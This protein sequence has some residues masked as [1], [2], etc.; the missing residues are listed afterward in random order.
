MTSREK[1]A[2]LRRLMK[3]EGVHAYV[4]PSND[5]HLSEYVPEFWK[6]REWVSGFTGSAGEVV[7]F[8]N[9]AGLWTDS[10]Y[11]LQAERQL[12]AQVV[13][14]FKVG[15]PDTPSVDEYLAK[16]LKRG[17][18][19]GI[20][21]QVLS[22]ERATA[23][24][25]TLDEKGIRLRYTPNFVD[26]LWQDRPPMPG[27]RIQRHADNLAG[28]TGEAKLN[29]MRAEMK[30]VGADAHIVTALDAIA[31]LFNV[32]GSDVAFVPVVVAYAVIDRRGAELFIDLKK[33]SPKL[34][35]WL[36]GFVRLRP[37]EAAGDA[38][39]A[40]GK[41]KAR[42]W[43]DPAGTNRWV[44]ERLKGAKIYRAP[45]PIIKAKAIKNEVQIRGLRTAQR[46]DGVAMV[47]F[48]HWLETAVKERRLRELDVAKK[49]DASREGEARYRGPSFDTIVGF[50]RNAAVVHYSPVT[51]ENIRLGKRGILLIDS[52]AQYL[53]GT[54]DITRTVTIGAPTPREK[55]LFTRVL[56]GN[57]NLARTPFP[58]GILGI[59]LEVLARQG[60]WEGGIEYGHG[61]G[62]GVGHYLS[63]HE[64]PIGFS[65][66]G[67]APIEPGNYISLEPG[68]YTAGRYGFRTENMMLVVRDRKR[69]TKEQEWCVLEALT[70]CPIDRE[71]I[72]PALLSPEEREW[73][74][75]YHER[76][77][78]ELGPRLTPELRDWL[79]EKTRPI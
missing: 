26:R 41:R 9:E 60:L 76:V 3:K 39:A 50:N 16:K 67:M 52:G 59:R 31:W 38:F 78:K 48:L 25:K 58:K 64:G 7:I 46:R 61:T 23:L 28:E 79:E 35:A 62:H 20:D 11:F 63:V 66:R 43:I 72:E 10:R 51:G 14:L 22:D 73:L 75:R 56:K 2:A 53:D 5:P 74:N 37:Y 49:C 68:C 55:E 54:T 17:Q 77:M 12:D 29:R 69:S 45:S 24:T 6:R 15:L 42:V 47:R 13:K 1:I 33:V 57:I 70:L 27:G 34:R 18:A 32:R 71:L 19:V 40:L 44:I 4:V 36:G 21:P 65:V 8:A 30:K